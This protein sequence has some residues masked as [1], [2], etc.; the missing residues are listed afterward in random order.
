VGGACSTAIARLIRP[1]KSRP[2][3]AMVHRLGAL[4]RYMLS[5]ASML[6]DLQV[7]SAPNVE[8][9]DHTPALRL[10]YHSIMTLDL[11]EDGPARSSP[12]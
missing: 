4:S 5:I 2:V 1:H 9:G 11:N 8:F 12:I 10:P 6:S 7:G 3:A